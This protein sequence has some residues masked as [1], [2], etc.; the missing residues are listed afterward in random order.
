MVGLQK[1]CLTPGYA[2]PRLG[3]KLQRPH[4]DHRRPAPYIGKKAGPWR[5]R[6]SPCAVRLSGPGPVDNLLLTTLP[7]PPEREGWVRIRV[8]AFDLNRS[9]LKFRLGLGVGLSV[10]RVPGIE[11]IGT[12]DAA[13]ADRHPPMPTSHVIGQMTSNRADKHQ[14][15]G[16]HRLAC[17]GSTARRSS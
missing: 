4:V 7:L 12:V 1:A 2:G 15:A 16:R 9:E 3:M 8:E 14:I 17:R 13:P 11:A 10:P 5:P 6:R